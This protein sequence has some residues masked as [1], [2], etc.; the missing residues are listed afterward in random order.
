MKRIYKEFA[1]TALLI[2][3]NRTSDLI[4]GS[5]SARA[6]EVKP[7]VYVPSHGVRNKMVRRISGGK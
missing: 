2:T 6:T 7:F 3:G 1:L 4:C 5:E